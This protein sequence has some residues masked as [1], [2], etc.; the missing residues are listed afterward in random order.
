MDKLFNKII[1]TVSGVG[2][3]YLGIKILIHGEVYM[4]GVH[5]YYLTSQRMPIGFI[6]I[7]IGAV[8]IVAAN[9]VKKRK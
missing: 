1:I 8:F 6:F 3:I 7:G 5:S 9:I 2:L 4:K